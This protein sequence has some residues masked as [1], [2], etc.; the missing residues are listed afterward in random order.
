MNKR[1]IVDELIKEL[2]HRLDLLIRAAIVARDA[3]T[4]EDSKAENKY[5]TR[6]LE[7]SYLA[8]AQ[9]RRSEELTLELHNLKKYQLRSYSETSPIGLTALATVTINSQEKRH[10]LI[11]PY[12]GGT[13]LQVDNKE[14]FVI[15]PDSSVGKMLMGKNVG[16]SF[17]LKSKDKSVEY[18]IESVV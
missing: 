3:A 4:G 6:G 17:E 16:D 10:F 13:K 11:L 7:A 9:A 1:K 12:A 18:E 8:G 5:D 2:E 14:I 15:T